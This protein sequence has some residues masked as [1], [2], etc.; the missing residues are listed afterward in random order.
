MPQYEHQLAG[1]AGEAIAVRAPG[2]DRAAHESQRTAELAARDALRRQ[3]AR[4]EHELSAIVAERFPFIPVP[5]SELAPPS[6]PGGSLLDL[7]ELER[8]RDRL[9]G[10]VQELEG[11][12]LARAEHERRAREKLERMKLEPGRYRFVRLPVQDLGQ[13]GCGVWEVR[14][15]LGL[16]G[17]LAGWWQ[18]K[19]SSGCPLPKGSRSTRDPLPSS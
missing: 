4:L 5:A 17:M 12:A 9:A 1:A 7:A 19:L 16:I 15:R 14:P 18:L 8:T 3:I 2:R 10:R 6:G 11:M 13:G